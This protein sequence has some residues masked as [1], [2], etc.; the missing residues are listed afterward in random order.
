MKR[1]IAA[2]LPVVAMAAVAIPMTTAAP[3]FAGAAC[4]KTVADKDGSTWNKTADGA[5]QRSGS[6]TGCGINGIAYNTH[7]L[8]YHCYTRIGSSSETWTF[9]RNDATGVSGWI[10]DDLLSDGGSLVYCGF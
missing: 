9:V 2:L 5:N 6:S 1:R 8:D 10:R 3:A 7:L 4:G